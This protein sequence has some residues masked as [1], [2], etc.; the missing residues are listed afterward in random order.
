[1]KAPLQT[2]SSLKQLFL[3]L[4]LLDVSI[5]FSGKTAALAFF[6]RSAPGILH[7]LSVPIGLLPRWRS[8]GEVYN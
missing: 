8:L 1:M 2:E 4:K 7:E 6:D 5:K 3:L